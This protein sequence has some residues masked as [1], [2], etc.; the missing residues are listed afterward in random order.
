M[1]TVGRARTLWLDG[2]PYRVIPIL[3]PAA[4]ETLQLI[5]RQPGI[6]PSQIA[7][8]RGVTPRAAHNT[9]LHLESLGFITTALESNMSG[10]IL[11]EVR[12]CYPVETP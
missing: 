3:R 5:Q 11:N 6:S 12:A 8:A 4:A 7:A 9:V 1:G 10:R 2:L